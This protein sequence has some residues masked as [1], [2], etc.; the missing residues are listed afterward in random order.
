MIRIDRPGPLAVIVGIC[1]LGSLRD[2]AAQQSDVPRGFVAA[3]KRDGYSEMLGFLP[4]GKTLLTADTNPEAD[5]GLTAWDVATGKEL[6]HR[7]HDG[8][9]RNLSPSGKLLVSYSRNPARAHLVSVP[10]L[11]K[12][13]ELEATTSIDFHDWVAISPGDTMVAVHQGRSIRLCSASSGKTVRTLEVPGEF[14]YSPIAYSPDGKTLAA[15]TGKYECTLWDVETWEAKALLKGGSTPLAPRRLRF[16]PESR[17]FACGT[18]CLDFPWIHS[19]RQNESVQVRIWDARTGVEL[20]EMRHRGEQHVVAMA[21]VSFSAGGKVLATTILDR[22]MNHVKLWG[23]D[24]W[25]ELLTLRPRSRGKVLSAKFSPAGRI[26]AIRCV[27]ESESTANL[28]T[29]IELWNVDKL[30]HGKDGE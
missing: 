4:D 16:S 18:G 10:A 22:R 25:K 14:F 15:R 26:L 23:S 2:A 29:V 17:L 27:E 5:L 28:R 24:R 3:I 13:S 20:S 7:K 30:L 8:Q 19:D 6:W 21:S 1:L 12:G 11:T 9:L